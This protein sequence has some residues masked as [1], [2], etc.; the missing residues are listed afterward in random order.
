MSHSRSVRIERMA[1][2]AGQKVAV[3]PPCSSTQVTIGNGTAGD[4][5]V[6]TTDED[7][8]H[9]LVVSA[10]YE[11]PLSKLHDNGTIFSTETVAF[12]LKAAQSGSVVLL[13]F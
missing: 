13:W 3:R 5:E 7:D 10:G 8:A 6:H 4:L 2:S 1:L 12:W 11:R 9:Y